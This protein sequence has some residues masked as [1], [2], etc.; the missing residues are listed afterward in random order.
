[1]LAGKASNVK[2]DVANGCLALELAGAGSAGLPCL[3]FIIEPIY[4]TNSPLLLNHGVA[5]ILRLEEFGT[6]FM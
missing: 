6:I 3:V 2:L 1:M 4:R 5:L